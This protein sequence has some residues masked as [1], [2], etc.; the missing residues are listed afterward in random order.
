MASQVS[1]FESMKIVD[2]NFTEDAL[3]A[4]DLLRKIID[5]VERPAIEFNESVDELV[6]L[7]DIAAHTNSEEVVRAAQQFMGFVDV[8]HIAFFKTVG[9]KIHN[10]FF[11]PHLS[12]FEMTEVLGGDSIYS[13]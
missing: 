10:I 2:M 12:G 6:Q 13:S 3:L 7:L 9:V 1:Y 4:I 5:K 8:G 11:P